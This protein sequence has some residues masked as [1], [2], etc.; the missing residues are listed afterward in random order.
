MIKQ[1]QPVDD[2]G[3]VVADYRSLSGDSDRGGHVQEP[4]APLIT[5][6]W[7]C[8]DLGPGIAARGERPAPRGSRVGGCGRAKRPALANSPPV[9]I[10]AYRAD[11]GISM[12]LM[13]SAC[14]ARLTVHDLESIQRPSC[15][16]CE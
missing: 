13:R 12:A 2:R 16:F 11:W 3:I 14:Q 9:T 15:A 1:G 5:C 8:R 7:R 6:A 10:P 4:I